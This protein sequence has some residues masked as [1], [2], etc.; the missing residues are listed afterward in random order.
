M[1]ASQLCESIE[2]MVSFSVTESPNESDSSVGSKLCFLCIKRASISSGVIMWAHEL[3]S[4]PDFVASASYATLTPSILS[5]ARIIAKRHKHVR[6]TILDL[7]IMFLNHKFASSREI[8][9]QQSKALKE[10][11]LRLLIWLISLGEAP[12]TLTAVM[13][14]LKDE[15]GTALDASLIRYFVTSCLEVIHLDTTS[16]SVPFI[17]SMSN[18]LCAQLCIDALMTNYF[19]IENKQKLAKLIHKFASLKSSDFGF[20]ESEQMIVSKLIESYKQLTQDN[21]VS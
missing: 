11:C 13:R 15:D 21:P 17:I 18:L 14:V 8:S 12:S 1:T 7:A 2:N 9:Y 10:Q 20:L 6:P 16:F 3:A 4:G 5:V 19:E